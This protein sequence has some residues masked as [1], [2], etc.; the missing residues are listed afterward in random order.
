MG[1]VKNIIQGHINE[2]LGN[3]KALAIPRRNI[4]KKCPLYHINDFWGWAECNSHLY[5]NPKTNQTSETEKEGFI[6]G[7]GCRIEAKITVANEK[8]PT[9][10][11]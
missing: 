2:F 7:C 3:K 8:C 5:L 11:W 9:G 10:K 6:K 4:C 1:G